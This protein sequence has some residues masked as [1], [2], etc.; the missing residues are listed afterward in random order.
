MTEISAGWNDLLAVVGRCERGELLPE[1]DRQ[2]SLELATAV[3]LATL[4]GAVGC[5]ITLQGTDGGFL[6]PAAAGPASGIL[7]DVQYA[8]GDGPCLRAAR[9]GLPERLDKISADPRWPELVRR[10]ADNAVVCSLSLPLITA[11][12]PAALNLYGDAVN[13]FGSSRSQE[14]AGVIARA[15]SALLTDATD[16]P[17]GGLDAA[18]VQRTISERSLISRAQGVVMAREAVDAAR[19][20]RLLAIRSADESSSLWEVAQRVLDETG[21]AS[22][23]GVS[24]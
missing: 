1:S 9:T 17:V 19:A 14:L 6:T 12:R 15:T 18:R 10:A 24:A 13:A 8:T 21:S 20:Y 4:P 23:E 7:D 5:S 16:R 2:A 3:G 22:A 11:R